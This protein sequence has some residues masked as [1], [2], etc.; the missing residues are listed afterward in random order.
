MASELICPDCGGV[1]GATKVDSEGR[2]PCRC[3]AEESA[4]SSG[5]TVSIPTPAGAREVATVEKLCLVCGKDVT[6]HRRIKDSRGYMCYECAKEEKRSE[7]EGTVP[8][9]EC[10]RRVKPGGIIDYHGLKI[11]RKCFEDHK[12]TSKR[13]IKKIETK[14][15]DVQE[16]KNIYVLTA[17]LVVLGAIM[18]WRTLLH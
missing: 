6:G 8:C 15:F 9:A 3:F 12:E 14:H 4:V 16:K 5:D 11:C 2:V 1:I 7:R 13:A 10:G 17:V 18:L